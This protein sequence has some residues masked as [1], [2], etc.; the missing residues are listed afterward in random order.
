MGAAAEQYVE[1]P[2]QDSAWLRLEVQEAQHAEEELVRRRSMRTESEKDR[3]VAVEFQTEGAGWE[4]LECGEYNAGFGE[5]CEFCE[6]TRG[7]GRLAWAHSS[8]P[9]ESRDGRC[10]LAP[11]EL[12]ETLQVD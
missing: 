12:E 4:C 5:T 6:A 10:D 3:P 8:T 1:E 2:V 9:W 7:A 11:L